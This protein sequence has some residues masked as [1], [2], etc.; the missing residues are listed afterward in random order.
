M[1][2]DTLIEK[3]ALAINLQRETKEASGKIAVAGHIKGYVNGV[4]DA[5]VNGS[6]Q[7]EMK[8]VVESLLPSRKG[9]INEQ[10]DDDTDDDTDGSLL[11]LNLEGVNKESKGGKN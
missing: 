7:G 11:E 8:V 3:T 9:E 1:L 10:E 5:D 6:V 4:I 2:G